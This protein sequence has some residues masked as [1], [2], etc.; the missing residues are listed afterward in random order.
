MAQAATTPEMPLRVVA[1]ADE[2]TL[3]VYDVIDPWYGVAAEPFAKALQDAAGKPVH[4][5]VNSPGGD[6]FEG[7]AMAT[8]LRTYAGPTRV[9]VEGLAA[10]AASY[11]AMSAKK[12]AIA[13][14]AF[15][16]IHNAWS[17]GWGNKADLRQLA[18]VLE[19]IDGALA[20][21]YAARMG[22][23][24]E[25]VAALLDAETWFGAQEAVD[26][27]LA[28]ELIAGF[29]DST[30]RAFDLSG[31]FDRAPAALLAA[32]RQE[33]PRTAPADDEE[34]RRL[35]QLVARGAFITSPNMATR[36][37]P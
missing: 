22:K 14:G 17:V 7:R 10:S 9:T 30:R 8:A 26:N 15:F 29:E 11:L 35:L 25:E 36:T 27:G 12:V 24:A 1:A 4:V 13:D 34:R 3:Y 19:Q 16:M 32:P 28:D 23:K 6:V 21:D 33:A 5:R 37:A 2:V 20:R 31:V 18:D